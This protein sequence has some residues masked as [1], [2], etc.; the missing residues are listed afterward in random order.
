MSCGVSFHQKENKGMLEDYQRL[1]K[2]LL[3]HCTDRLTETKHSR[4]EL[5]VLTFGLDSVLTSF[6]SLRAN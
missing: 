5:E 4:V 1:D 2:P 6:A 3:L